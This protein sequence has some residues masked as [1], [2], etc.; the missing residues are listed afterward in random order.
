[1]LL[2]QE[3]DDRA[4][5]IEHAS[6]P[7]ASRFQSNDK[8]VANRVA[9]DS[10]NAYAQ[11]MERTGRRPYR[12]RRRA[13]RQAET[14]IRIV[15][16]AVSLFEEIGPARTTISAVA[17]RAG[18]QR[19]TVYRHFPSDGSLAVAAAERHLARHPLPNMTDWFGVRDP[20]ARFERALT[21]LYG[22]YRDS[23]R[24]TASVLRD[25]EHLPVLRDGLRPLLEA[26]AMLPSALSEGWPTLGSEGR[27]RLSA[28]IAHGIEFGTWRS[29]TADGR[30][31][32]DEAVKLVVDLARSAARDG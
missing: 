11:R 13:E 27:R 26:L 6:P 10:L 18:V 9:F 22:F 14:R 25:E 31:R 24:A 3:W 32:D 29:L 7:A 16:A 17:A 2:H 30:L 19:L 1:M 4:A 28:V 8:G 12:L 20:A 15:D 21:E 5:V 23:R